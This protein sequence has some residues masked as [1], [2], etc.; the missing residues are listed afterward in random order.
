MGRRTEQIHHLR[1]YTYEKESHE[2]VLNILSD[3]SAQLL[4]RVDS[5]QPHELQLARPP[6]SSWSSPKVMSTESV[7]PSNHLILLAPSPPAFNLS[8]HQGL[9]K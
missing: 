5:L 3:S 1:R 9:F 2:K 8:Q 6:C 7:M 4:S